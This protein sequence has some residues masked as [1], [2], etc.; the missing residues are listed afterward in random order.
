MMTFRTRREAEAA[1][2]QRRTD[3]E[4]GTAP[5]VTKMTVADYLRHWL[6]SGVRPRVR[7]STCASYE[8]LIRVQLIPRL[9]HI[10]LQK[11]TAMHVQ[12]CYS[13]LRTDPRGDGKQGTLSPRSICY[14]HTVLK[15]ALKQAE[16]WRLV[17]RNVAMDMDA[18]KS[19]RPQVRFWNAAETR[20]FLAV[21]AVDR[22]SGLWRVALS[23]G[24]RIGELR[25]LRW[26]DVDFAAKAL[27]VRQQITRLGGKDHPSVP[28][29]RVGRR[30]ITL[31]AEALADL[32]TLHARR[33]AS[34]IPLHHAQRDTDLVFANDDGSPLD[35][36]ALTD[37]FGRVVAR[38]GAPRITFHG[39]RHTHATLLLLHGVNIKTVSAR[40]GHSS[41]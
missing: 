20:Q 14:A 2:A 4:R 21:A 16:R 13:D 41:V 32:R 26:C 33:P 24:M 10:P 25:G 12:G 38:S 34:P 3:F 6:E 11:L 18:P 30:T 17:A 19:T 8:R 35:T 27:H 5:D 15:M 29:T 28:K 23:T 39:M 40:M 31:P 9:G 1:Q 36:D 22:H 37:R 7:P